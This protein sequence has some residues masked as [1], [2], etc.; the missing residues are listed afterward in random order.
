MIKLF[1][2]FKSSILGNN[3]IHFARLSKKIIKKAGLCR[4][5]VFLLPWFHVKNVKKLMTEL[6]KTITGG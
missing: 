1:T 6:T 2:N 3:L 4:Y 5:F